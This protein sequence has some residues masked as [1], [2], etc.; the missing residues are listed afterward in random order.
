MVTPTLGRLISARQQVGVAGACHEG[1][2]AR[3]L[4]LVLQGEPDVRVGLGCPRD[5]LHHPA[6]LAAIVGL[7]RIVVSVLARPEVD[8]RAAQLAR[9]LGGGHG[10]VERL[11]ADAGV[12]GGE[13]APPPAL[14]GEV[15]G[16]DRSAGQP[17][18]G[19]LAPDLLH[20]F[21]R[22]VPGADQLHPLHPR[23][24]RRLLDHPLLGRLVLVAAGEE[25]IAGVSQVAQDDREIGHV[26]SPCVHCGSEITL[27]LCRSTS[28]PP[29]QDLHGPLTCSRA[30][31]HLTLESER[32]HSS[33]PGGPGWRR[34][35]E[36]PA[37]ARGR[38]RS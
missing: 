29:D 10:L 34:C 33:S 32:G 3:L 35:E 31:S 21:T 14:L 1:M 18:L 27:T 26:S 24:L 4:G 36:G 2:G 20:V 9:H 7:E 8:E 12:L 5:R 25:P 6:P 28:R 13:R 30:A 16:D 15:V 38:Q 37:R 11:R 22:D 17:I 19:E 23:D